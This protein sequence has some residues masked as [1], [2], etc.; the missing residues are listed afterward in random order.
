MLSCFETPLYPQSLTMQRIRSHI[1]HNPSHAPTYKC[2]NLIRSWEAILGGAVGGVKVPGQ[3]GKLSVHC[4]SISENG[5][6]IQM[7]DLT[8]NRN[9]RPGAEKDPKPSLRYTACRQNV[10]CGTSDFPEK[11]CKCKMEQTTSFPVVRGKYA[12]ARVHKGMKERF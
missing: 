2:N 10:E 3:Q 8:E 12:N 9:P 5:K 4:P 1:Q 11:A 7:K 6:K